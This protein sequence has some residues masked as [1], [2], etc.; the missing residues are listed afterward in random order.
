MNSKTMMVIWSGAVV[1]GL[2]YLIFL[3]DADESAAFIVGQ[4]VLGVIGLY[5]ECTV[6]E[7]K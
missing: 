5:R 1:M 7:C 4:V 6:K 3:K 2:A